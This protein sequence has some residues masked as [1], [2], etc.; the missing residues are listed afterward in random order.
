MNRLL[1]RTA[2]TFG[3]LAAAAA[4]IIGGAGI[5]HSTAC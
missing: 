1:T 2:T 3:V 4:L 5:A